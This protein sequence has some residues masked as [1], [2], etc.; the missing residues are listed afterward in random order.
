MT[1]EQHT[2]V[3]IRNR[4]AVIFPAVGALLGLS[5]AFLVGP[6]VAWLLNQIGDAPGPLR[7]AALLP[8]AWAIPVLMIV[9]VGV[10][11]VFLAQW[12]KEAGRV[13]VDARGLTV[14]GQ[15]GGRRVGRDKIDGVF[16]DGTDLVVVDAAGREPLRTPVDEELAAQLPAAL[17]QHGLRHL[18]DG[19]PREDEFMTWVDGED[20]L[21]E[22]SE[23]LLRERHRAI[24]DQR[25]GRMQELAEKL[26]DRG[27]IVRD[28]ARDG[29]QE[30][31][32]RLSGAG[33]P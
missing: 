32:Y 12:H 24:L 10:G 1:S 14:E 25:P 19:D 5:A 6:A 28:R 20:A 18:G 17:A 22:E 9:G 3:A 2:T 13:L 15:T 29:T 27:V 21:A 16:T 31:Q 8:L 11:L 4:W 33:E 30:Q 23:A 7:L 26:T